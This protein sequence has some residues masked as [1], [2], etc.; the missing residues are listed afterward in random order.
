MERDFKAQLLDVVDRY[1]EATETT[2]PTLG[3]EIMNDTQF[4]KRLRDGKSCTLDTATRVL[5]WLSERWPAN[6]KWPSYV[7]RPAPTEGEAA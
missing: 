3:K 6:V 5:Q 7:A 1:A 4:F 2:L